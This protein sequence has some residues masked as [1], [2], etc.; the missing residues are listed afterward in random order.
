MFRSKA[1]S[2]RP[3]HFLSTVKSRPDIGIDLGHGKK[4][5]YGVKIPLDTAISPNKIITLERFFLMTLNS[6]VEVRTDIFFP[7][8]CNVYLYSIWMRT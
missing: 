7:F 3:V 8:C 4:D 2:A 6:Y 5:A 1:F